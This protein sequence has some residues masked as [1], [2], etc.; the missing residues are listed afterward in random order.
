MKKLR[1]PGWYYL[2]D[3]MAGRTLCFA[4]VKLSK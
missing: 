4:I 1:K 2:D 3:M